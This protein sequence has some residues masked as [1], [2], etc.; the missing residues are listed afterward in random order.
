MISVA[1]PLFRFKGP[2]KVYRLL[3]DVLAFDHTEPVRRVLQ[4]TPVERGFA[5]A[6]PELGPAALH[7]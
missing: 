5:G 6:L 4:E 7:A 3:P 1:K 2:L